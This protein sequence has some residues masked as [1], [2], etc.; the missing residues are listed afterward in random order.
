MNRTSSFPRL[1]IGV[2]AALVVASLICLAFVCIGVPYL[3]AHL[4]ARFTHTS[5]RSFETY[6]RDTFSPG[7][8]NLLEDGR[9]VYSTPLQGR[10]DIVAQHG[11]SIIPVVASIDRTEIMPSLSTAG[12]QLVFVRE[13]KSRASIWMADISGSN[14]R[15]ITTPP[16][17]GRDYF[18]RF[19]AGDNRIRFQ[20][21]CS[22]SGAASNVELREVVLATGQD[23]LVEPNCEDVSAD[24]RLMCGK[25]PPKFQVTISNRDGS[26]PKAVGDGYCPRFS[27]DGRYV[28]FVGDYRNRGLHL[29]DV[30]TGKARQLCSFTGYPSTPQFS[31][32][33]KRIAITWDTDEGG[34][35]WLVDAASG[36]VVEEH[37]L[38]HYKTHANRSMIE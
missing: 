13:Y 4:S 12:T 29:A 28:A 23:V 15:Q 2:L 20:R 21:M 26:N 31:P 35:L 30:V 32:D 6:N 10:G 37:L 38:T 5:W 27:P 3:V 1:R 24:G 25:A 8:A 14:A 16:P 7:S 17:L 22:T 19:V 9:V 33:G 18:P 34:V 11:E 36:Q